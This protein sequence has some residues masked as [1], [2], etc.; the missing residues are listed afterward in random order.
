MNESRSTTTPLPIVGGKQ[1]EAAGN[2]VAVGAGLGILSI[3]LGLGLV[4]VV[5]GWVWSCHKRRELITLHER[6]SIQII[7]VT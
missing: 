2:T 7:L 5:I 3:V 1:K 6:Y 4:G